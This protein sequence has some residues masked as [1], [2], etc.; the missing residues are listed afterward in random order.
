MV[1]KWSESRS[2]TSDSLRPHGLYS[3]WNFPSQNT[4]VGSL[5][6]LQGIFPTLSKYTIKYNKIGIIKCK[7]IVHTIEWIKSL[8]DYFIISMMQP[9]IK[10]FWN[11]S[12]ETVCW[13]HKHTNLLCYSSFK[14]KNYT[15]QQEQLFCSLKSS[16]K[17][18]ASR[19]QI[20]PGRIDFYY[21]G[22]ILKEFILWREFQNG[23]IQNNFTL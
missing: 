16:F 10:H 4:G 23:I 1:L 22:K 5:S 8:G 9:L 19:N 12:S 17:L 21:F 3:P 6:L 18:L 11:V 14:T 20:K 7:S 15:V 2:V 13:V